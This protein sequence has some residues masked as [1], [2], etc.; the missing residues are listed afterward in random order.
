MHVR[1]VVLGV[2]R[3]PGLGDGSACLDAGPALD[4]E[5]TRVGQRSLVAVRRRDRHGQAVGRHLAREG[6]LPGYRGA[7]RARAR[8]CDVDATVLPGG[9]LVVPEREASENG[10][11]RGP[12][13]GSGGSPSGGK[14]ARRDGKRPHQNGAEERKRSRGKSRCCPRS[15]HGD[16][17]SEALPLVSTD[18]TKLS[19]RGA[20]ERVTRRPTQPSNNVDGLTPCDTGSDE[21]GDC[22]VSVLLNARTLHRPGP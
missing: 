4:E 9:V 14:C 15:E 5:R 8:E 1:H 11:V 7:N 21:L 17:G 16:D 2:A 20:V 12:C 6:D 18:V 3:R 19:Q 10:A 13:P 22:V